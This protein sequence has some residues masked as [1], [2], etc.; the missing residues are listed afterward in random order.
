MPG[1]SDNEDVQAT[2]S[3]TGA[4]TDAPAAVV[5]SLKGT[6]VSNVTLA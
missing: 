2:D 1:Q 4:E 5:P 3:T 6:V